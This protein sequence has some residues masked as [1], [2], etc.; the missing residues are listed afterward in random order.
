MKPT[1]LIKPTVAA[2]II[3]SA[4]CSAFADSSRGN[5]GKAPDSVFDP[6]HGKPDFVDDFRN[7]AHNGKPDPVDD[8]DDLPRPERGKKGHH[9]LLKNGRS[10]APDGRHGARGGKNVF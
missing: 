10:G 7:D 9:L 3:L 8:V 4:S 1:A 6:G 2:A 5:T